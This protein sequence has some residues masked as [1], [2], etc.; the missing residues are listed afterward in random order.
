MPTSDPAGN[1]E[2]AASQAPSAR[3][4]RGYVLGTHDA[5]LER[6][7]FQHSVWRDEVLRA[8]NSAGLGPGARVLDVGAGPGF[9]SLDLA[10]LVGDSGRVVA[11][12]RSRRFLDFLEREIRDRGLTNVA[13]AELDLMVDPLPRADAGAARNATDADRGFDAAWCR[14]VACFVPDPALLV[15]RM[16]EALRPGGRAVFHEYVEYGSYSVLPRDP[17]VDGFVAAVFESWRS[18]GGEPDIAR[19]LPRMLADA[20]LSIT[21][22]RPIARAARPTDRLWHWP[23]GFAR[24]NVPRLVELGLRSDAWGREVIAAIDAAERDEASV[25][26]TPTVLEIIAVKR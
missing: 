21:H 9:A 6:L 10:A 5:E 23:A 24:I 14:W 19:V 7:A 12:E 16:A 11:V 8:W 18:L 15:R 2:S 1:P 22:V 4:E 17:A 3:T 26:I 25:F 20:G 13:T